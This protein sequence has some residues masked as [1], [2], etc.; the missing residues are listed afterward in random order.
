MKTFSSI[1]IPLIAGI[2]VAMLVLFGLSALGVPGSNGAPAIGAVV[3]SV[4]AVMASF[5]TRQRK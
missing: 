3:G 2:S 4:A 1:A 5:L